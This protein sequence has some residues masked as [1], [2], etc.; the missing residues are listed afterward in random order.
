RARGRPARG[1]ARGLAGRPA[2]LTPARRPGP[3]ARP[4]GS[5]ALPQRAL[6][7][8]PP[9]LAPNLY[10]SPLGCTSFTLSRPSTRRCTMRM[11]LIPVLCCGLLFAAG[12]RAEDGKKE[13][14]RLQG[15]WKAVVIE[16][17][18]KAA[19]ADVTAPFRVLVTGDRWRMRTRVKD[20]F[21]DVD[22]KVRL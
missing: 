21:K 2:E 9:R 5:F 10:I 1:A 7:R 8:R 3:P 14:D 11:R 12:S 13:L 4:G 18:G 20:E 19:P 6:R 17:N 22:Y 16:E 15:T